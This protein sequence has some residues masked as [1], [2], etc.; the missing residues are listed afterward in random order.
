MSVRK[1]L[2]NTNT[3]VTINVPIINESK[4]IENQNLTIVLAP[5]SDGYAV[6]EIEIRTGN[7]LLSLKRLEIFRDREVSKSLAG[8][9]LREEHK[10]INS[11]K[12]F[13]AIVESYIKLLSPESVALIKELFNEESK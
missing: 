12:Q 6:Y 9:E 2:N 8:E 13:E 3:I 1:T 7:P 5:V 11:Y 4:D 10:F